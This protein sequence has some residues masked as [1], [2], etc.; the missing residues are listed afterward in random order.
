MTDLTPDHLRHT[1]VKPH[2]CPGLEPCSKHPKW[3]VVKYP[4]GWWVQSPSHP[5]I[6]LHP[7]HAEAI[8]HADREA[9]K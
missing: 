9:R 7:T 8:N 5:S 6:A 2:D 1:F 3:R 4:A